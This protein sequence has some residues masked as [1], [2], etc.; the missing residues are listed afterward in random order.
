MS[1][2][3]GEYLGDQDI[4]SL[5]DHG[6]Q[7]VIEP[8]NASLA[9]EHGRKLGRLVRDSFLGRLGD[10]TPIAEVFP[11]IQPDYPHAFSKDAE[12]DERW[13]PVYARLESVDKSKL[14]RAFGVLETYTK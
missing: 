3:H 6:E 10:E 2:E 11:D 14:S 13:A 9:V 7:V 4:S 8:F 12:Q 5:K 1:K